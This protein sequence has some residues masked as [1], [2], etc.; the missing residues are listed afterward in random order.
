MACSGRP[1]IGF[2]EDATGLL[3][4]GVMLHGEL[5]VGVSS[6]CWRAAASSRVAIISRA[7]A[8]LVARPCGPHGWGPVR[9]KS[10]APMGP[11]AGAPAHSATPEGWPRS[12]AAAGTPASVARRQDR[13]WTPAGRGRTTQQD[14][15]SSSGSW[16]RRA[17][18]GADRRRRRS[19]VGRGPKQQQADTAGDATAA[20][21]ASSRGVSTMPSGSPAIDAPWGNGATADALPGLRCP[22]RVRRRS[23]A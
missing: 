21:G 9:A 11:G 3:D 10:S 6:S 7:K 19:A 15:P 12:P 5:Q 20:G 4:P 13:R 1:S 8:L 23:T 17:S 16:C 2:H 18:S 14:G 22:T